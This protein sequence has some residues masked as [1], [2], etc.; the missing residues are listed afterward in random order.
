MATYALRVRDEDTGAVMID[1]RT[2]L[3]RILDDFMTGTTNGSRS[4][5]Q[6]SL[7]RG[8]VSI[9]SE[10]TG[11]STNRAPPRVWVDGLVV[12][13]TFEDVP[14]AYMLAQSVRVIVGLY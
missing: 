9:V 14:T 8:F 13:W 6:L 1:S 10:N 12:R 5:P 4:V 3:S 2:S 11:W 7:G